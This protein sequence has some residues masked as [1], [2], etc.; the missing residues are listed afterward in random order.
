[1]G[2]ATGE[3]AVSVPQIARRYAEALYE[4]AGEAGQLAEVEKDMTTL[5][6]LFDAM[7]EVL[8]WCRSGRAPT[9]SAGPFVKTAFVP[10]VGP[11]TAS[12]LE[13]AARHDRL[14]AL[15]LL[16]AAFQAVAEG[17]GQVVRVT[18][19]TTQ[20]PDG[21]FL[22]LVQEEMTRRTGKRVLLTRQLV[23]ELIAG[24]R[25]LWNHRMLDG[26]ARE[27][28]RRLSGRLTTE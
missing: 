26:T 28:L 11:L 7:P 20:E 16:P 23:P 15:P 14:A 22:S 19:E 12:T 13:V 21:A 24:F 18:L 10:Y 9:P 5:L 8:S 4:V 3:I 17:R 2:Q 25:I 1:M 27:R 6:R